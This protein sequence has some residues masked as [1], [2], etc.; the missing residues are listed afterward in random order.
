MKQIAKWWQ[1]HYLN[2]LSVDLTVRIGCCRLQQKDTMRTDLR[3]WYRPERGEKGGERDR[4]RKR[5]WEREGE[6]TFVATLPACSSHIVQKATAITPQATVQADKVVG[7]SAVAHDGHSLLS[8]TLSYIYLVPLSGGLGSWFRRHTEN[9][10]AIDDKCC[11]CR[12]MEPIL[13][14]AIRRCS[15]WHLLWKKNSYLARSWSRSAKPDRA[16]QLTVT[17]LSEQ[18]LERGMSE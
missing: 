17:Q 15:S 13:R 18:P 8:L 6:K 3:I 1:C 4:A 2:S 7:Q 11:S 14:S 9:L 5:E 12:F 10:S 16:I